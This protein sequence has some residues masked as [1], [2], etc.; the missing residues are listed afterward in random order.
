M[1]YLAEYTVLQ[2]QVK[3]LEEKLILLED[4]VIDSFVWQ[5]TK[6]FLSVK[7]FINYIFE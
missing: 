3:V 2:R 4:K 7:N 1:T 6:T 5:V